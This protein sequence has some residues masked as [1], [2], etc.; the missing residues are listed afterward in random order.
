VHNP[1]GCNNRNRES[2]V[3]TD[4]PDRMFDSQNNNKGGY[5]WGP[6]MTFYEG[7]LLQV[8]WT[9]QHGCGVDNPNTDCEI[10]IQ[11][12]CSPTVRDG[13]T[14]DTITAATVDTQATDTM[15]GNL[16]YTYG[17]HEPYE[18]YSACSQRIRNRGLFIADQGLQ[19][20]DTAERTR[21]NNNQNNPH[22][23]ECEE[24]RDYYPYWHPTPWRDIAILTSN[25]NRCDYFKKHSQNVEGKFEC[26]GQPTANNQNDCI[27]AGGQWS[28]TQPWNLDAP[29]CYG[30]TF[31]RDNHLGNGRTGYT[32]S[33]SW[34]IPRLNTMSTYLNSDGTAN[35]ALRIRYNVTSSDYPGWNEVDNN[36]HMIDSSYNAGKSPIYQDPYV[37]YGTDG[38]GYAWQLRLALNT[39]QY[40][41]TFQDRSYTFHI[42]PRPSDITDTHRIFNLNVRGKRGNIVEAY[43]AVEY[44]FTPGDLYVNIG[45]FIHFQWTGCDTNPNYA[46]EG[47]QRT[48]RSNIVQLSSRK[49][50]IPIT[51][52]D[53]TLFDSGA[54]AMYF[55]HLNQYGGKICQTQTDTGCCLTYD[56]LQAITTANGGDINQN[57]QNCMKLNDPSKQYFAGATIQM[58]KQGVYNYMSTRNNNFTNRSQ[59]GTITVDP[60]LPTWGVAMASIGSVGFVSAS[61]VAGA[62]YYAT[63]HPTSAVA[64]FFAGVSV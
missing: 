22:G 46:G 21:Q 51:F 62:Y 15:T 37:N 54:S 63:T 44:D 17:M 50:N 14:T 52:S 2:S 24:E 59:K 8:E 64:N 20:T 10:I 57:P 38:T 28:Y 3:N 23:F 53:Q 12:M 42:S 47:T 6:P 1:R 41:R 25:T 60:L 29:D 43:P 45:D 35:C 9:N 19:S 13:T 33:Y 58:K 4:N 34:V 40:C 16:A 7:S 56:Q 49:T 26:T 48:D 32:P 18:Y 11:Y 61:A 39:N 55:A 36:A 27:T 5:C 31:S 30:D